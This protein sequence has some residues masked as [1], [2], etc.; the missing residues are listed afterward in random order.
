MNN[1]KYAP[2]AADKKLKGMADIVM[3]NKGGGVTAASVLLAVIIL[4]ANILE[5]KSG[6]SVGLAK[7][8]RSDNLLYKVGI[9]GKSFIGLLITG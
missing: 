7:A 9:A 4:N 8:T 5:N 3:E 2:V 1:K 6:L